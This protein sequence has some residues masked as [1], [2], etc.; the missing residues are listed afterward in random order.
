MSKDFFIPEFIV[1]ICNFLYTRKSRDLP[2]KLRMFL[3]GLSHQEARK[4]SERTPGLPERISKKY[5]NVL[6]PEYFSLIKHP[7]R[8]GG[9]TI[10]RKLLSMRAKGAIAVYSVIGLSEE[11]FNLLVNDMYE[12][13]Y[14]W[15][16]ERY[17]NRYGLSFSRDD[18]IIIVGEKFEAKE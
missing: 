16:N 2:N 11:K 12:E 14:R 15:M 4:E 3:M 7:E 17:E 5:G 1:V 18:L 6:F 10:G 9:R 8:Y 13:I